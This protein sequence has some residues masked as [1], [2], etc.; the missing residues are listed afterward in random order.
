MLGRHRGVTG[1]PAKVTR[2]IARSH[3]A[4]AL[5]QVVRLDKELLQTRQLRQL[6]WNGAAQCIFVQPQVGQS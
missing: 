6:G 3:G 5:H 2:I 4:G 1:R